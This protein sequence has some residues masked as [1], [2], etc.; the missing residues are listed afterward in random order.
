[1]RVVL[2]L[3]PFSI[4]TGERASDWGL[5]VSC[6]ILG[7][8]PKSVESGRMERERKRYVVG[9]Y[10]DERDQASVKVGARSGV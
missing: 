7:A 6:D 5:T 9:K 8:G 4:G 3:I 1:M 2:R 10:D